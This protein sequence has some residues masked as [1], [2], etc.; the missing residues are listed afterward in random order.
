M[1]CVLSHKDND[2]YQGFQLIGKQKLELE[3]NVFGNL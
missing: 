3:H 1:F 2:Y